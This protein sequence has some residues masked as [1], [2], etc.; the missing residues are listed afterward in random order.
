ML[1]ESTTQC[2]SSYSDFFLFVVTTAVGLMPP[3][4]KSQFAQFSTEGF[5]NVQFEYHHVL[6]VVICLIKHGDQRHEGRRGSVLWV[7]W[8]NQCLW[9]LGTDS[10][11]GSFWDWPV[12]N[13]L[14][15]CPLYVDRWR[16]MPYHFRCYLLVCSVAFKQKHDNSIILFINYCQSVMLSLLS[17]KHTK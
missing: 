14:A 8:V 5:S 13:C 16:N 2:A 10:L 3:T 17:G 4:G 7:D 12:T 11:S 15:A 6:T 9:H 1:V